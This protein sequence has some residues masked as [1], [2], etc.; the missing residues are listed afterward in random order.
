MLVARQEF[1]SKG[2]GDGLVLSG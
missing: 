1:Y 2:D